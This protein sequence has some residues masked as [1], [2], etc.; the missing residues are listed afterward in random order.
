MLVDL[1]HIQ[2]YSRIYKVISSRINNNI[3]HL[4]SAY[5]LIQYYDL[6]FIRDASQIT[7][8][9]FCFVL[10]NF[11]RLIVITVVSYNRISVPM[12][13]LSMFFLMF[14][15]FRIWRNNIVYKFYCNISMGYLVN[16]FINYFKFILWNMYWLR[17]V[18]TILPLLVVDWIR[19]NK[20]RNAARHFL[21]QSLTGNTL[22][23]AQIYKLEI[24]SVNI[25]HIHEKDNC[26]IVFKI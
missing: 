13:Y 20:R 2:I 25:I 15:H 9:L 5:S 3:E 21:L 24:I 16:I 22:D 6:T 10:I 26:N 23:L 12:K 11:V 18:F 14:D 1:N 8:V 17:I 7:E 4:Y 19:G